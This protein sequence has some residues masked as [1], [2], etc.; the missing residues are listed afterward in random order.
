MNELIAMTALALRERLR[1]GEVTPLEVLDALEAHVAATDGPVNALPTL[2]FERARGAAGAVDPASLLAGMPV[3]I[4]DLTDVAGVRTTY[5]SPAFADHVPPA[6]GI[7]VERLEAN[8]ALIFAKSN[9]PEFGAGAQ[10]F[11]PVLGVT[12]NPHDTRMSAA[13]SS[14]GAAAA[15][16]TGQAW[17]AHGSDMGGSLRNPASFC[18][19]VG[20]RPSPGRV[21]SDPGPRIDDTLSAE[22]PMARNVADCALMLDAM[23]GL[24]RR[25]PFS[26]PAP[27]TPFLAAA[28]ER[29][30]PRRVA[31]SEG[32]GFMPVDPEVAAITRAAALRL[33]EAGVEVIEATPDFAEAHDA[34]AV[35]RA[36]AFAVKF[37]ELYETR[38]ELLKRDIV[39]NV[40]LGRRLTPADV[41]RAERARQR[42][43]LGAA[44]FF[45]SH[46][47]LLSPATIVPAFAVTQRFV[48]ECA[49][50]RFA[51]YVEWLGI[52]YA[53]TLIASPALSLPC[54]FTEAG[55]PFGLQIAAPPRGEAAIFAAAQVL[56]D[57]LAVDLRPIAPRIR[58]AADEDALAVLMA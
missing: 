26:L 20:L 33:A 30:V 54:G 23:V 58:H 24:D 21:A 50:Q 45:A 13:G 47:L 44:E 51:N 49:G 40:E 38:R 37:E 34:F 25:S 32:L 52:A 3:P 28:Q 57:I 46:D 35:L 41:T 12:R 9:T 14:G 7:L 56:E 36:R 42:M 4:K 16:A 39:W 2:C 8:G 19:V 27:R 15:L 22:G 48:A 11:N 43:F 29:R 17:L 55:L 1:A 10:T 53:I 31:Y 6:S 5:G 18:G